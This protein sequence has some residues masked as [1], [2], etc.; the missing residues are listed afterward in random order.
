[1]LLNLL[2]SY[3]NPTYDTGWFSSWFYSELLFPNTGISITKYA[4]CILLGIIVVYLIQSKEANR[5]GINGDDLLTCVAIVVPLCI[6]G[7]RV[8]YMLTDGI[9][10]LSEKI[11]DY[12]FFKGLFGTFLYIFGF[13]N[14]PESF[15][16]YGLSGLAIHGGIIVALIM[17]VVCSLIKKWS[18]KNV[19]DF[20]LP[21]FLLAQASGRW[22]NFFNKECN[23]IV[24]GGW[25][26]VSDNVLEANLTIEEQ[27]ARLRSF[28][29][30]RFIVDNMCFSNVSYYYGTVNGERMTATLSGYAYYHPTFLYESLLNF[31]AF[32]IY[33]ILRRKGKHIKSGMFAAMYLI[34][35]GFIRFLIEFIRT[36]SLYINFFGVPFKNAQVLGVIMVLAGIAL[37]IYLALDKKHSE[38]YQDAIRKRERME[39]NKET[40]DEVVKVNIDEG[41][42]NE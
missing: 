42:T 14:A 12:G 25:N 3:C 36:D 11:G 13:E 10:T 17:I 1:M 28:G 20:V 15:E 6:I 27:Y 18:I 9:P 31:I 33:L 29:I 4:V 5:M 23:G 7:A 30:P 41:G 16:F 38:L 34:W 2:T 22:G 40:T 37:L 39:D 19:A 32:I 26:L 35:Y 8:A 21:G 24:V